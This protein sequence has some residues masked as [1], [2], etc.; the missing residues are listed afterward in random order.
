[1]H[2]VVQLTQAQCVGEGSGVEPEVALN[3]V[4]HGEVGG[5]GGVGEHVVAG[6][7]HP[8][9]RVCA[10]PTVHV[11]GV[12]ERVE[13]E[14]P[15]PLEPSPRV[16][17]ALDLGLHEH[18]P[19]VE[20]PWPAEVGRE[21]GEDGD[22]VGGGGDLAALHDDARVLVGVLAALRGDDVLLAGFR[23]ARVEA[24]ALEHDGG[25][26]EDEVDGAVDVA[27]AVE[28]AEG[29]GVERVLVARE[30]AAVEG[31]EVGVDAQ[32]HGLVLARPR[33]VLHRQVARQ[34]PRADHRC[35]AMAMASSVLL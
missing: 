11:L 24:A 23:A 19:R 29:V 33:R 34:E 2:W 13:R 7:G 32:R 6:P 10:G 9:R 27:V 16:D 21:V 1:M 20:L 12:V 35:N 5:D 30:A 31:G 4:E 15:V 22:E 18:R 8:R 26:P 28:L 14:A 25:V 17:E 3:E